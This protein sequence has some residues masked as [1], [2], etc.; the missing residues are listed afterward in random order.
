MAVTLTPAQLQQMLAARQTVVND[1]NTNN[2]AGAWNAAEG[3]SSIYNTN[4]G[5]TTQDP[6]LLGL[7]SS[8]GLQ[9]LD[10][11]KQWN[12]NLLSQYYNAFDNNSVYRGAGP[13]GESLGKNPYGTWGSASGIPGDITANQ[14]QEGMTPDVQRFVGARPSPGFM[15]KWGVPALELAAMVAAPYAIGAI[16]PEMAAGAAIASGGATGAATGLIG[17]AAAGGLYGAGTG[18]L[19]GDVSGGNVG[20]DAL[21]GGIGGGV[22]GGVSGLATL[23]G[24][25]SGVSSIAGKATGNMATQYVQQQN[26][27][28]SVSYVPANG[29][30]GVGGNSMLG[31]F[32]TIAGALMQGNA[33]SNAANAVTNAAN[34]AGATQA[35]YFGTTQAGWQPDL[36]MGQNADVSL[37]NL[38]SGT[39][40]SQTAAFE[41][42]PGYQY[43]L[44]QGTAAIN[45]QD[46]AS[47]D[48]YSSNTLAAQNKNA[49]GLAS[50]N[51]QSYVQNLMQMAGLGN[52]GAQGIGTAATATGQGVASTRLTGGIAQ[53]NGILGQ[54]NAFTNALGA[55]GN[56]ASVQNGIQSAWNGAGNL[57]SGWFSGGGGG[58]APYLGNGTVGPVDTSNIG[59]SLLNGIGS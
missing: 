21:L 59:A 26:A 31:A 58:A 18:A 12:S 17:S 20:R 4:Y 16:A 53:G 7:E 49:Q 8:Q 30:V 39:G 57:M 34:T 3:T 14:N 40:S 24:A 32:G 38:M 6:L 45:K 15:Q 51:Y 54:S 27:D 44:D 37:G 41:N 9:A 11:S 5:A 55:L 22:A 19:I 46:A 56:N 28:G 43:S 10:P 29:T 1:L 36:T 52:A 13:A 42:T 48:L 33:A 35:N 23:G 2:F 47:G 25:P 50:T